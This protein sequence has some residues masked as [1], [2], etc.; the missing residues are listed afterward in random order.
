MWCCR[1][2]PSAS[3]HFASGRGGGGGGETGH[4]VL[5]YPVIGYAAAAPA[6]CHMFTDPP[7]RA[8]LQLSNRLPAHAMQGTHSAEGTGS[9]AIASAPGVPLFRAALDLVQNRKLTTDAWVKVHN[10][11]WGG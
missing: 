6:A 7:P 4:L 9:A 3:E 11:M 1:S 2:V 5:L 8:K 10:L